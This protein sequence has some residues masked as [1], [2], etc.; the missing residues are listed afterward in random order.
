MM[1]S[2]VTH[3][4]PLLSIILKAYVPGSRRGRA[5]DSTYLATILSI[6]SAKRDALS[7]LPGFLVAT[8]SAPFEMA[9]RSSFDAFERFSAP[10]DLMPLPSHLTGR[11]IVSKKNSKNFTRACQK[12]QWHTYINVRRCPMTLL[13]DHELVTEGLQRISETA[14]FLGVSRSLVYQLINSGV[15]PTVRLGRS[16]RIPIRAVYE[17]AATNLSCVSPPSR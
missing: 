4:S 13:P 10:G 14:R 8:G 16:R 7:A 6:C 2:T 12:I 3:A 11:A 15:L 5:S 9:S 17:L 1:Q